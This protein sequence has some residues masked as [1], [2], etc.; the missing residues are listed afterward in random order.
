M[1]LSFVL[2]N[3]FPHEHCCYLCLFSFLDENLLSFL[4]IIGHTDIAGAAISLAAIDSWPHYQLGSG[5]RHRQLLQSDL[6]F[7]EAV[8]DAIREC[9]HTTRGRQD[10]LR[11]QPQET[12][13]E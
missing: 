7:A 2:T 11:Q 4:Q 10:T 9:H 3:K 1:F 13:E 8:Q 12:E 5:Q 6:P